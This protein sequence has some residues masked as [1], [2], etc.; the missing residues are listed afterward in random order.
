MVLLFPHLENSIWHLVDLCLYCW[1]DGKDSSSCLS[2]LLSKSILSLICSFL[3]FPSR[4]HSL[5]STN[6]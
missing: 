6:L 1:T 5:P 2:M 3:S 4:I